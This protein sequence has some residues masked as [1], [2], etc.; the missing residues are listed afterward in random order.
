MLQLIERNMSDETVYKVSNQYLNLKVIDNDCLDNS[1]MI[2]LV[3]ISKTILY[4]QEKSHSDFLSLIN[5]T[6]NH[7]LRNPLNSIH[8]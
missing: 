3:D 8:A 1:K 7:E 5:A 2:S 4:Y 6:V